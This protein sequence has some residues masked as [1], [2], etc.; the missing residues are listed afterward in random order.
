[1][2]ELESLMM[3]SSCHSWHF[4]MA[5][6]YAFLR[7]QFNSDIGNDVIASCLGFAYFAARELAN[8][9]TN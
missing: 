4:R 5:I 6:L 3:L 9:S 2:Q 7:N 1:M 8:K